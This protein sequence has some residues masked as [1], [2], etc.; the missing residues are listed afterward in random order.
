[1]MEQL[2]LIVELCTR[3]VCLVSNTPSEK[4]LIICQPGRLKDE[5]IYRY[6]DKNE[7]TLL[8]VVVSKCLA[9]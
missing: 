4:M 2:L 6:V 8:L 3:N 1:M 9:M 7:K 5:V